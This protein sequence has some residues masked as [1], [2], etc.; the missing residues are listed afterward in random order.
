MT[1][2]LH[3][4]E[5]KFVTLEQKIDKIGHDVGLLAES[6]DS[7]RRTVDSH[8]IGIEGNRLHGIPSYQQRIQ[9]IEQTVTEL[10]EFKKKIQYQASVIAF[11]VSNIVAILFWLA[12]KF[13]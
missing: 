1:A 12:S 13:L 9:K 5:E 4:S 2:S 6:L 3:M 7:L 10:T 8:N 11:F